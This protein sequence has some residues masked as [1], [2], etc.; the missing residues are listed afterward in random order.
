[1]SKF[2]SIAATGLKVTAAA[3][4]AVATALVGA[5]AYAIKTGIEF[6]TAFAGVKKTVDATDAELAEMREGIIDLSKRIPSSAAAIAEVAEAAGQLG[7]QNKHLISFTEVMTNLGV[8]TNMSATEAATSLARLANITGMPQ[9]NFDRLGSTVVALGNNLATTESEIVD[10]GLRLAGAGKQVGMT[11]AQIM[12]MSGA[13]S[14]VGIAADAGGSAMSTV[15]SKMQLA[16]EKGGESLQNFASV[17]GMSASE[18]QQAFHEDAAGAIVSFVE[19]LGNMDAQGQSAIKTLDDM[20]I[21][22]IRQRDALLRLAGAGDILSESIKLGTDAWIENT[23]LTNEAEQKYETLESRIQILKN[24]VDA[25]AIS[26]YDDMRPALVDTVNEGIKYVDQL[27]DA[28]DSGGLQG[29]VRA[30]GDI[31]A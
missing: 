12:G 11:E 6:E 27:A 16:V 21:T 23:A 2:N 20:G 26:F 30:A 4:A 3:V 14:S 24:T 7:I 1:M 25:V 22:E 17:A 15:M 19:G 13:L 18:F 9:E 10:M 31:F 28:F 29:V 8:A 5:G